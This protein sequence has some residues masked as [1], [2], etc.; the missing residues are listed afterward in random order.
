MTLYIL[1]TPESLPASLRDEEGNT[2]PVQ[3]VPASGFLTPFLAFVDVV[4]QFGVDPT[5]ATDTAK[6]EQTAWTTLSTTGQA[7]WY[8]AGTYLHATDKA[9][10]S[11]L[12]I[13]LSPNTL[14]NQQLAAGAHA[15]PSAAWLI[16]L[17]VEGVGSGTLAATPTL[18]GN[19]LSLDQVAQPVVGTIILVTSA[20]ASLG[21]AS[22]YTI[23][24]NVSGGSGAWVVTVDRPIVFPFTAADGFVVYT[25]IPQNVVVDGN[26]AVGSGTGDQQWEF[27]GA[28]QCFVSKLHYNPSLGVVGSVACEGS[29]GAWDTGSLSCNAEDCHGDVTGAPAT[30]FSGV[31]YMQSAERCTFTRMRATGC[32]TNGQGALSMLDCFSCGIIDSWAYE[33]SASVAGFSFASLTTASGFGGSRQCYIRGGGAVSTGYGCTVQGAGTAA[34]AAQDNSISDWTAVGCVVD[35]ID[36][37][38]VNPAYGTQIDRVRCISCGGAGI[39][40]GQYAG[41]DTVC[42]EVDVSHAGGGAGHNAVG[43]FHVSGAGIIADVTGLACTLLSTE[44]IS[45][46]R[47]DPGATLRLRG[48]R[49]NNAVAAGNGVYASGSIARVKDAIITM[50]GHLP[51]CVYVAAGVAFLDN[52]V[53]SGTGGDGS[54]TGVYVAA[55]ATARIGPGCDFKACGAELTVAAGGF[56]NRKQTVVANGAV[57]VAVAWPDI[58]ATDVVLFTLQTA[59]GTIGKPSYTITEGTGFTFVSQNLDTSTY[60]YFIP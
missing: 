54:C 10:P 45:A 40:I 51:V 39:N 37:G 28:K 16:N 43:A 17:G 35:G 53:G 19:Q 13:R 44:A 52:V 60:E 18:Y 38:V 30:N 26:D 8:P 59:G 24:S 25:S 21:G 41:T 3:P 6:Q 22:F 55:G 11:N 46:V 32:P 12:S 15:Y 57:G 31:Y 4:P 1:G 42:T 2:Y 58:K 14:I 5:G 48:G 56:C 49:I 20:G 23:E 9:V 29:V 47:V 33:G 34:G 36:V 27:I 50:T 7:P